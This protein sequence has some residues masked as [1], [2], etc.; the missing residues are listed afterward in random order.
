MRSRNPKSKKRKE[1]KP[2]NTRQKWQKGELSIKSN[3]SFKEISKNF[4]RKKL[5]QERLANAMKSQFSVKNNLKE[6]LS[7][8]NIS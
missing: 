8:M 6:T 1:E 2:S 3:L 4:S 7:N 5:L